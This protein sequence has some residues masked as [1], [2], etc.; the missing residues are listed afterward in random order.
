MVTYVSPVPLFSS[1]SEAAAHGQADIDRPGPEADRLVDK[2]I[3][4][5]RDIRLG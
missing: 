4:T 1:G 3:R 5:R 2:I